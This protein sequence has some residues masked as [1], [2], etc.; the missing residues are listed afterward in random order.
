MVH[1]CPIFCSHDDAD[2][3]QVKE[4]ERQKGVHLR[5]IEAHSLA[6][7]ALHEEVHNLNIAME[8]AEQQ[9]E[10]LLSHRMLQV[11]SECISNLN[12]ASHA[13]LHCCLWG[14]TVLKTR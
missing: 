13:R 6:N 14:L 4:A 7:E 11:N 2:L 12:G 3:E 5:Q 8:D 1:L 9:H 10:T